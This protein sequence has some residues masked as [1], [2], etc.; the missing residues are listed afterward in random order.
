MPLPK[1]DFK[2]FISHATDEDGELVRWI[3]GALDRLHVRAFVYESYQRGG[4]NR[5]E[6]IK[7]NI[8]A[9]PYFL[10]ILTQAG[11]ASQ[12][13]N[14]EIGYAVGVGKTIIPVV[15]LDSFSG[16]RINSKGFVEI[17]DPL[18]YNRNKKIQ[19]M[20]DIIYTL[21]SWEAQSGLWQDSIYLTC[22]CGNEFIGKLE[23]ETHWEEW[24]NSGA[25]NSF[26]LSWNCT[27]C[28]KNVDL[29]FPDCHMA[30]TDASF[31]TWLYGPL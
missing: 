17:H 26:N 31:F 3:A 9:C 18:N 1:E 10:V 30:S 25:Q 14:Q 20:A 19:L 16:R 23:F 24:S 15:E 8:S 29:S 7:A 6:V 2:V 11:I 28:N 27:K 21:Y 5:F 22:Q 13:V 4:Q 12:W